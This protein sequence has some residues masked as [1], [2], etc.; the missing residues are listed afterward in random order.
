MPLMKPSND[1]VITQLM[2][3][4][5]DRARDLAIAWAREKLS[6]S[7]YIGPYDDRGVAQSGKEKGAG[8]AIYIG[9]WRIGW[10]ATREE[11]CEEGRK[12]EDAIKEHPLDG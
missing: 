8:Y 9:Q 5:L 6:R 7:I 1:N 3:S 4:L 10:W 2:E 12:L 11:A